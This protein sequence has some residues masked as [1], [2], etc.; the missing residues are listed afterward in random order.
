MVICRPTGTDWGRWRFSLIIYIYNNQDDLMMMWGR[1]CDPAL[2]S[3]L[4]RGS[5]DALAPY[6]RVCIVCVFYTAT[7]NCFHAVL[8]IDSLSRST[9]LHLT[10]QTPSQRCS[11]HCVCCCECTTQLASFLPSFLLSVS[12]TSAAFAVFRFSGG[13]LVQARG[14]PCLVTC[15][16]EAASSTRSMA[17]RLQE[18]SPAAVGGVDAVV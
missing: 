3:Q 17:R 13:G 6:Y 4:Q 9:H 12:S 16:S 8:F 10:P 5:Y 14:C 1:T 18:D 11:E 2:L 7:A 15:H